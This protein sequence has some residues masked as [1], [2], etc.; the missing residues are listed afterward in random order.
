MVT[1]PKKTMSLMSESVNAYRLRY[2]AS[3]GAY[4]PP[5]SKLYFRA[6]GEP[7][8]MCK[9]YKK[10]I[11]GRALTGFELSRSSIILFLCEFRPDEL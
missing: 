3:F 8:F 5:N 2:I 9:G 10:D 4:A 11:F 1:R 7:I 6:V